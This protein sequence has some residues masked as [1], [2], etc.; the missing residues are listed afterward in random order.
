MSET[1]REPSGPETS[2][3]ATTPPRRSRWQ[4]GL[5]TLVLLMATIAVWL[6]YF[7][8]RRNIPLLE[9]RIKAMQPLAHELIVD[10]AG[11]I[12]VVKLEEHWFDENQWD[13][14]LPPG[15]YRVCLAT[16]EIDTDGMA[17]VVK[18]APLKPGRRRLTLERPPGQDACRVVVTC[19]GKPLLA[20][21]EPKEWDP[22]SGSQGG[23]QYSQGESLAANTPVVLF[24][25]RFFTPRDANGRST[26]PPHPSDG[27]LLWV[28]PTTGSD[29]KP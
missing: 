25:R 5:R 16:R 1:V 17:P 4:V 15:S 26:V 6:T 11:K 27:I 18:S 7:V 19:D 9:M 21:E 12:A 10:D 3:V 13:L 14:Y 23:G 28:E 29:S 24:R 20:V 22:V 2:H 8:N